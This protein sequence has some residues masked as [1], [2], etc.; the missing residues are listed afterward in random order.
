MQKLTPQLLANS[1]EH[2]EAVEL[3]YNCANWTEEQLMQLR[4]T[5]ISTLQLTEL[6]AQQ[7][8]KLAP[9][10]PETLKTLQL[11][12]LDEMAA[13]MLAELL[14]TGKINQLKTIVYSNDFP[15]ASRLEFEAPAYLFAPGEQTVQPGEEMLLFGNKDYERIGSAPTAAELLALVEQHCNPLAAAELGWRCLKTNSADRLQN[16][17]RY[18]EIAQS[19]FKNQTRAMMAICL[20]H[21]PNITTSN[22]E[23]AFNIYYCLALEG[24]LWAMVQLAYCYFTGKGT[25]KNLEIATKLANQIEKRLILPENSFLKDEHPFVINLKRFWRIGD[26]S[27]Y[28]PDFNS[29]ACQQLKKEDTI[30]QYF[31]VLFETLR[32][33]RKLPVNWSL[34]EDFYATKHAAYI[35]LIFAQYKLYVCYQEGFTTVKDQSKAL[36]WIRMTAQQGYSL[37]QYEYALGL[38]HLNG[39]GTQINNREAFEWFNIAALQGLPQAQ[40]KLGMHYLKVNTKEAFKWIQKAALQGLPEA[41]QS[42]ASCYL[43]GVGISQNAQKAVDWYEKAALRGLPEAQYNLGLCY[44]K[45]NGISINMAEASKWMQKAAQQNYMHAQQWLASHTSAVPLSPNHDLD[46]SVA[47][48]SA[49]SQPPAFPFTYSPKQ[50]ETLQSEPNQKPETAPGLSLKRPAG[51]QQGENPTKKPRMDAPL[52]SQHSA[53]TLFPQTPE[54]TPRVVIVNTDDDV[55]SEPEAEQPPEEEK[56]I[57]KNSLRSL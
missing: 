11:G 25:N 42:L 6:S 14:L 56:Q 33:F 28:I 34:Q 38:C 35:S 55:S 4:T 43:N 36:V 23:K 40:Y 39:A 52:T 22:Q 44:N 51:L 54:K 46:N 47:H 10:L 49:G 27:D 19:K 8:E 7:L 29:E 45:G 17:F 41:Q 2:F 48:P 20:E 30:Y 24:S 18:F 15:L 13:T 3:D 50:P 1:V 26:K 37:A 32:I 16:A 12:K 31:Y 57:Y 5:S 53:F 9:Y 21:D